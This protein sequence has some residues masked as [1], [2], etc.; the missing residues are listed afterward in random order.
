MEKILIVDDSEDSRKLLAAILKSE[1]FQ[2][3]EAADGASQQERPVG[4]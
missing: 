4:G 1:G 3:Q 2:L